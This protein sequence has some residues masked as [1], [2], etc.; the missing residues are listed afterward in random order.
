[1][2]TNVYGGIGYELDYY[3]DVSTDQTFFVPSD[4]PLLDKLSCVKGGL[5]SNTISL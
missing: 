4:Y 3:Q 5:R 1:M 2:K